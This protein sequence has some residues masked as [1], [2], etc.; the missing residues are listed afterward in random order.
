MTIKQDQDA[1]SQ[2]QMEQMG[3]E[4]ALVCLNSAME[5]FGCRVVLRDFRDNFPA[6][7]EETVVQIG[8]LDNDKKVAALLKP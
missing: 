2:R 1:S 7:F 3:Y 4:D 8:R 6:M 5:Q